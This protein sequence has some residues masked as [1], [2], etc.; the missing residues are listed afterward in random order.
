VVFDKTG[1]IRDGFHVLG[2]VAVPIYL[3]DGPYPV[4]FDG[5]LT[6]LGDIY[7]KALKQVLG[8]RT[9]ACLYLTHVHFDHCGAVPRLLREY[10]EMKVAGSAHA[11]EILKRPNAVK[12]IRELN[13]DIAS[14]VH[15][16]EPK[17]L[18][19]ESFEPFDI[20]IVL[21]PESTMSI[22]NGLSMDVLSTPG[23]TWD[24][25]SFCIPERDILV[26]SEAVG[27]MYH[28]GYV[29]CECLVDF[30]AYMTSLRRLAGLGARILCQSHHFV[31]TDD[32]VEVFL[33]KSTRTA[34]E[35]Q[36]LAAEVYKDAGGNLKETLERVKALEYDPL[37]P[38]KQP[39]PAYRMNLEARLK[40]V[41]DLNRP[42]S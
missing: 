32:D 11:K 4:I 26:A 7:V 34:M 21:E 9:P 23:H 28:N 12:L 38:P 39:E 16:I 18:T 42:N 17:E 33:R 2:S 14:A 15:G 25:F 37:L 35:F 27:T 5:G 10:P 6:C 8:K 40:S 22:Q 31:F 13:Q 36:S 24:F 29:V 3:L 1:Y 19:W 41:L 30:R 20:D